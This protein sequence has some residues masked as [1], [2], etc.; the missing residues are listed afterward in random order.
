[1]FTSRAEHRLLLRSDNADARLTTRG[2]EIGLVNDPRLQLWQ[3]RSAR[4]ESLRASLSKTSYQGAPLYDFA[5]RPDIEPREIARLLDVSATSD[6][7]LVD[8]ICN[9]MR[10]EG[11]IKRSAAELRRLKDAEHAIIPRTLDLGAIQ[12]MR[13]EG[14]EALTKFKPQTL[15][16][17][18]RLAGISPS[19]LALIALAVRRHARD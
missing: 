13:R 6:V 11:Y 15:G 4:M 9:D 12:G 5:K 19:D 16:Q 1:M 14:S 10:Y 17:A 8:R 18:S 2:A 3:Q 7:A